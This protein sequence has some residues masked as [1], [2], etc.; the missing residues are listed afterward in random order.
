MNVKGIH[1][2][3]LLLSH[4]LHVSSQN[5]R[6]ILSIYQLR[7]FLTFLLVMYGVIV[8]PFQLLSLCT[9]VKFLINRVSYSF[10]SPS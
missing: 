7:F 6:L 5:D 1:I 8:T 10:G 9:H 3:G 2:L 4:V